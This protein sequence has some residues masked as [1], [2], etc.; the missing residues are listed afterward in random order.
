VYSL[1]NSDG[2]IHE[3]EIPYEM[4]QVENIRKI[5]KK[6]RIYYES[7]SSQT[8]V[9]SQTSMKRSDFSTFNPGAIPSN[10]FSSEWFCD[11]EAGLFAVSRIQSG[12]PIAIQNFGQ[13]NAWFEVHAK[14]MMPP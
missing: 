3:Y 6:I 12:Q 4:P 5:R 7:S 1:E 9:H 8:I 14:R 2:R 10:G 11:T 13:P